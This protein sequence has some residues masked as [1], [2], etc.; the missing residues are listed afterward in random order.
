MPSQPSLSPFSVLTNFNFFLKS[1]LS[2]HFNR[3]PPTSNQ[4][5]S[6]M[7]TQTLSLLSQAASLVSAHGKVAVAT[8]DLGGNSTAIGIKIAVVPGPG[9]NDETEIDTTVFSTKA[10][11]IDDDIRFTEDGRGNNQLSDL[12]QAIA[13]PGSTLPHLRDIP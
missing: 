7:F 13:L 9:P 6:A 3:S 10:I 12:S 1:P 5:A 8:G 2:T 4:P 11:T